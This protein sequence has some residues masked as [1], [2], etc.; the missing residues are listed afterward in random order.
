MMF[1]GGITTAEENDSHPHHM[2]HS[3]GHST[4]VMIQ[5]RRLL[6]CMEHHENM[7]RETSNRDSQ[8]QSW[9]SILL[10]AQLL[11]ELWQ[12]VNHNGSN[13][14]DDDNDDDHHGGPC[15]NKDWIG[16][17]EE[18]QELSQRV[19]AAC[20]RAREIATMERQ[21][22][23]RRWSGGFGEDNDENNTPVDW[24]KHIFFDDDHPDDDNDDGVDKRLESME[25]EEDLDAILEEEE[26]DEL[27]QEEHPQ[28]PQRQYFHQS[29]NH[30]TNLQELQEAQ[31]EQM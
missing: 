16:D 18:Y 23:E 22:A 20:H 8:P 31:R 13:D 7:V 12:Q 29:S 14:Y 1:E 25:E 10:R 27:I 24:V 17:L 9:E 4:S 21:R 5:F 28:K 15:S 11:Q 6:Y 30:T 19:D 26:D 3:R 2:H